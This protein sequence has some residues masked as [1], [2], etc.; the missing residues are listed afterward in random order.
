MKKLMI[1]GFDPFGG[2]SVNP[3]WEAVRRLP[4]MIG[5]WCLTKCQRNGCSRM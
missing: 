4:E 2:E 5:Q 1:T 3:S